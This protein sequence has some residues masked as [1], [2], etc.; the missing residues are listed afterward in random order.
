MILSLLFL[1]YYENGTLPH[2]EI[3]IVILKKYF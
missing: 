2:L 1:N 3:K